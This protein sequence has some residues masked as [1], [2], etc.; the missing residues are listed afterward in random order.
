MSQPLPNAEEAEKGVLCAALNCPAET[1]TLCAEY[2]VTGESL[3]IGAHATILET[4]RTLHEAGR[5]IDFV[6]VG[7]SLKDRGK[8]DAIGGGP[9]LTELFFFTPTYANTRAYLE[10]IA[11]KHTRRKMLPILAAAMES[12]R[13][14]DDSAA[15][16]LDNLA[17]QVAQLS[18]GRRASEIA[19]ITRAVMDKLKRMTEKE[20][21]RNV[22][23]TGIDGLDRHSP[24]NLGDMPIISG[25]RKAGKSML[26]LTILAHIG[27]ELNLP[28]AY[29]SLED[30][31]DA[32]IDRLT[33]AVSRV[34]CWQHHASATTVD[35]MA[36]LSGA[37]HKLGSSRIYVA[38]DLFDLGAIVAFIKRL[39]A[40]EP[41]LPAV[42]VD[43]A[44]LVRAKEKGDSRE[45]EVAR[46][47]RTLRLLAMELRVAIIV[48]CQLNKDSET[49]ES[50]ALEMDTTA[51]WKVCNG[52]EANT[53]L[54][55]IPFQRNGTS[56]V[57]FALTF[58][59]EICRFENHAKTEL[60]SQ[61]DE[62]EETPKPKRSWHK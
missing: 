40:K 51:M 24:L 15:V 33:A 6:T 27:L 11:D 1:L 48:L 38:D 13:Q 22:I 7:Q 35:T 55:A 60:V 43:Y 23:R 12:A 61:D 58:L 17:G 57:A 36:T 18:T 39:K 30:R 54:L 4:I 45:Q 21:K 3:Y 49:R 56:N 8:L 52:R 44:Q 20:P 25:E 59:G 19:P 47:S 62:P 2:F 53:K 28:C 41:N 32:V 9:K 34:P 42:V 37:C 31:T 29:V 26:A 10:E 50:K 5:P 16:L 14:S 46:I